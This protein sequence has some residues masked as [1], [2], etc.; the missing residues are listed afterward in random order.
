[1]PEL[2][3]MFKLNQKV[4]LNTNLFFES[5]K[6]KFPNE[7]KDKKQFKRITLNQ[8]GDFDYYEGIGNKTIFYSE[9]NKFS[10]QFVQFEDNTKT[11]T[12]NNAYI[13]SITKYKEN[14]KFILD[15]LALSTDKLAIDEI[16]IEYITIIEL[17]SKIVDL[18]NILSEQNYKSVKSILISFLLDF[19]NDICSLSFKPNTDDNS[20]IL[21]IKFTI[22]PSNLHSIYEQLEIAYKRLVS[23]LYDIV[24]NVLSLSSLDNVYG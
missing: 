18:S 10:V 22:F 17:K 9:D 2:Y 16:F 8:F 7:V 11:I 1:M 5:I 20:C 23:L 19:D 6:S 24:N 4:N 3:T 15:N 21:S 14:I 13:D 12:L